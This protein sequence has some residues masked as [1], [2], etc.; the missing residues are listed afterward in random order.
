[1]TMI[2]TILSVEALKWLGTTL[3]A[4]FHVGTYVTMKVAITIES[5][6]KKPFISAIQV[7]V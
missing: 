4:F 2:E 5:T 3:K 7:P 6:L 1:M